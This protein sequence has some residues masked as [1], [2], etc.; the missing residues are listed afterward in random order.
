MKWVNDVEKNYIKTIRGIGKAR[1][2]PEVITK[3]F[4]V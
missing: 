1:M 4:S 3:K 2:M